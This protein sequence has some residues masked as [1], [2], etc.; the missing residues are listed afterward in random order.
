MTGENRMP[1]ITESVIGGI[2]LLPERDRGRE[3]FV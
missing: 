2:M 1:S 3:S